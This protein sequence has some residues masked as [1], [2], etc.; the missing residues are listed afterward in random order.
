MKTLPFLFISLV[1]LLP[2]VQA[3]EYAIDKGSMTVGG[4]MSFSTAGGDLYEVDGK[5]RT[6]VSVHPFAGY[7]VAPGLLVAGEIMINHTSIGNTSLTEYGGGPILGYYLN[8]HRERDGSLGAF[9]PYGRM[10]LTL[11][12]GKTSLPSGESL[13]ATGRLGVQ[14]GGLFML[15]DAVGLDGNIRGTRDRWEKGGWT[16]PKKVMYGYTV[17]IGVGVTA[18][19]W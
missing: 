2:T 5:V 6:E 18:F 12:S 7:F 8:L 19:L 13:G 3:A 11:S 15:S 4:S 9:Y 17:R 16:T 14:L 10:F 1:F